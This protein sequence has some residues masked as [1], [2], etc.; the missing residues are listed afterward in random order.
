MVQLALQRSN[1]AYTAREGNP[2]FRDLDRR[3][4]AEKKVLLE[5][6]R[7]SKEQINYQIASLNQDIREAQGQLRKFPR[8]EQELAEIQ[9]RFSIS[10]EAYDLFTAKRSEAEIIRSSNV[11][12]ILFIDKAKDVGN[13]PIGPN[14]QLNTVLAAF[15]GIM[16]PIAFILIIFFLDTKIGTPEDVK[17]SDPAYIFL[18]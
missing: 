2:A 5:N 15:F 8:E 1:L 17:R 13:D 10:Q 6:I 11:S 12:D 3:I 4:N 9:R 7:S 16:T 18:E 14:T